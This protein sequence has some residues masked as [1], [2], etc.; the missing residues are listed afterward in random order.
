[1]NEDVAQT[2]GLKPFKKGTATTVPRLQIA[3]E[4]KGD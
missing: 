4:K 3:K 1:V 2:F